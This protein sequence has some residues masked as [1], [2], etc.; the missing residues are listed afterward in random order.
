MIATITSAITIAKLTGSLRPL[1]RALLCAVVEFE[2]VVVVVVV[3]VVMIVVVVVVVVL[4][5]VV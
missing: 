1:D 4:A 5:D 3:V 2:A